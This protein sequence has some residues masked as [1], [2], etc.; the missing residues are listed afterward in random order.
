MRRPK[1]VTFFSAFVVVEEN[2]EMRQIIEDNK[3]LGE[4]M[5]DVMKLNYRTDSKDAS[6]PTYEYRLE[7]KIT[8]CRAEILSYTGLYITIWEAKRLY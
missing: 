8:L 1:T 5:T 6:N 7:K 2:P 3:G 4:A